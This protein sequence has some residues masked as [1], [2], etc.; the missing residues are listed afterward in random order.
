MSVPYAIEN[1]TLHGPVEMGYAVTVRSSSPLHYTI[2][3]D[4]PKLYVSD[5][6]AGP[7]TFLAYPWLQ[8]VM[9]FIDGPSGRDAYGS[10]TRYMETRNKVQSLLEERLAE[11]LRDHPDSVR[12]RH[13]YGLDPWRI[14]KLFSYHLMQFAFRQQL[15]LLDLRWSTTRQRFGKHYRPEDIL[16][17][18]HVSPFRN[19]E[20]LGIE[21]TPRHC[22]SNSVP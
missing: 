10:P 4:R 1:A 17:G 9:V 6:L 12:R 13:L 3:D 2:K 11:T 20:P 8:T 14:E 15:S 7:S 5:P 21:P 16:F 18:S 22:R 19:S